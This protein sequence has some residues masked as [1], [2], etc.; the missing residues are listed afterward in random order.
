MAKRLSQ[1]SFPSSIYTK[2]D[3]DV[4]VTIVAKHDYMDILIPVQFTQSIHCC[5]N[6]NVAKHDYVNNRIQD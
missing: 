5:I 6:P 1:Y 2:A 3:I 4:N